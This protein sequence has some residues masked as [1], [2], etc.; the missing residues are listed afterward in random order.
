MLSVCPHEQVNVIKSKLPGTRC[1]LTECKNEIVQKIEQGSQEN[2][3]KKLSQV[4]RAG[5]SL[6]L[7]QDALRIIWYR[8][9]RGIRSFWA[10]GRSD[11]HFRPVSNDVLLCQTRTPTLTKRTW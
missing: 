6:V 2:N 4:V 3:D 8:K 9:P 5:Q 1:S 10:H 7:P 11:W